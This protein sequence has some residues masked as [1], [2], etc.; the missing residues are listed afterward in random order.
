VAVLVPIGEFSKMT[1]LNVKAL[2]HYH[3]LGLLEPESIEASSGYRL[4][5]AD[6]VPV[7]QAIRRFRDLD[8]PLEDI[9]GV[10]AAP[11]DATRNAVILEHLG[12]M[13]EPLTRTQQTVTSLQSLLGSTAAPRDVALR[14]DP[15]LLVVAITAAVDA[16][17]C[18]AWL[19][20]AFRELH[21]LV[22]DPSW[23][24]GALYA[25]P[26]FTE[27]R[28]DVTAF[29]P[30]AADLD[31]PLGTRARVIELPPARVAVLSHAGPFD[32]IDRTYGELGTWVNARGIGAP[33]PIR[34]TYFS[35]TS[36]EVAWPIA[37]G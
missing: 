9:R 27:E 12:R 25:E 6:Q 14:D 24:D 29:L 19:D 26:F 1:Y 4:Y 3:D 18:P 37:E 20:D 30:L 15:A 23:P 36:A 5:S 21:D 10:L 32:D 17:A 7:A 35:D 28:G 13:Q 2:R 33:G 8:M 16:E 22:P 31:G 34:E 11:D